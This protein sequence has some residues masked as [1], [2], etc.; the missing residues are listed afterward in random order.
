LSLDSDTVFSKVSFQQYLQ[1]K[2]YYILFLLILLSRI[3]LFLKLFYCCCKICRQSRDES[4]FN[5]KYLVFRKFSILVILFLKKLYYVR[6]RNKLFWIICLIKICYFSSCSKIKIK[7]SQSTRS[8]WSA[9]DQFQLLYSKFFFSLASRFS[10]LLNFDFD[11]DLS[12]AILRYWRC[13]YN[14]TS[15]IIKLFWKFWKIAY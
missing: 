5:S 11:F 12:A 13:A 7:F 2:L 9:W 3:Y 10:L 15:K 8:C 1:K 14:K 4:F 6:S